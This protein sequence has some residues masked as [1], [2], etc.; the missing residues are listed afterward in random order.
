MTDV[1]TGGELASAE[2]SPS[3]QLVRELTDRARGGDLRPARPGVDSQ[4][5]DRREK[6]APTYRRRRHDEI[7]G[8][9]SPPSCS[10][11]RCHNG[12]P[13]GRTNKIL[14]V[15]RTGAEP[16][17]VYRGPPGTLIIYARLMGTGSDL[18]TRILP[19]APGRPWLTCHRWVAGASH[20]RGRATPTL[21]TSPIGHVIWRFCPLAAATLQRM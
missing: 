16:G 19:N 18:V 6:A 21:L 5:E 13:E 8:A 1:M 20:C 10:V 11:I 3:E 17:A 7:S 15:A 2:L 12:Q 9:A 14:W 4:A